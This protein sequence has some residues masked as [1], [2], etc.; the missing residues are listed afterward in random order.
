MPMKPMPAM[1]MRIISRISIFIVSLRR[2][3]RWARG[4]LFPS[5]TPC[6]TNTQE[7]PVRSL[8]LSLC[9]LVSLGVALAGED[10]P[11]KIPGVGTVGPVV[12]LHTDFKFTEG[13]AADR[14][15]NVYFSD[16]PNERIHK[17]D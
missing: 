12:K 10:K 8:S 4:R 16:I 17:V 7:V 6:A 9:V 1:P 3:P 15:G 11:E 13:P 2:R 5:R 14:A